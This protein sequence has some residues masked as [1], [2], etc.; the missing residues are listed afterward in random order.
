LIKA[1]IPDQLLAEW[2]T[3]SLLPSIARDV[4]M[5]GVVTEEHAISHAQYLD[6]VYS[7][8]G[9][10]Y[11]LIPNAPHP[12]KL[13]LH[14]PLNIPMPMAWLVCQ[15]P[16]YYLE[17]RVPNHHNHLTLLPHR[18]TLIPNLLLLLPNPRSQCGTIQII[19]TFWRKEEE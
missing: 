10:L 4:T 15:N 17:N 2:F 19:P 14:V 16:V 11:D 12:V 13:I 9:T 18:L 1:H 5:G 3:K 7:Q 6:L 8:T